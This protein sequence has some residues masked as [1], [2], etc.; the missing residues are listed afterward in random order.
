MMLMSVTGLLVPLLHPKMSLICVE[1]CVYFILIVRKGK[2]V[3]SY[4]PPKPGGL[5]ILLTQNTN[6]MSS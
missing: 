3:V 5:Q 2:T 1:S 6:M 4:P